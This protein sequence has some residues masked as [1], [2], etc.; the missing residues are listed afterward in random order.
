[1]NTDITRMLKLAGVELLAEE[2]GKTVVF[3]P[4]S[5]MDAYEK[6]D[7]NKGLAQIYDDSVFTFI[8]NK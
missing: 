8:T 4:V 7:H 3:L 2:V 6:W 1:M 5:N